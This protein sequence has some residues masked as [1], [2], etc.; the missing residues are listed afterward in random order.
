[1][2]GV[3]TFLFLFAARVNIL[4]FCCEGV[5]AVGNSSGGTRGVAGSGGVVVVANGV[6]QGDS[7]WEKSVVS[8]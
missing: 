5:D 6:A 1:M 2:G 8:V 4:E 3:A 7:G